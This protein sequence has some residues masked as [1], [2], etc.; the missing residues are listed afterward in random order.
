MDEESDS[1]G[2]KGVADE[3]IVYQNVITSNGRFD[4]S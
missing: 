4:K 1:F 2:G 3:E